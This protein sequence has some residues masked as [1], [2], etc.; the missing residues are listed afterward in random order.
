MNTYAQ[1]NESGTDIDRADN[2]Q[3]PP[4]SLG[5]P[6][7]VTYTVQLSP[8]LRSSDK[9]QTVRG[10]LIFVP[11]Q[12]QNVSMT[13][14][15][16]PDTTDPAYPGN[17]YNIPTRTLSPPIPLTIREWDATGDAPISQVGIKLSGTDDPLGWNPNND[18][19]KF[20]LAD[21]AA[22]SPQTM[23]AY[24]DPSDEAADWDVYALNLGETGIYTIEVKATV[25][26]TSDT[27]YNSHMYLPVRGIT[28]MWRCFSE[29]SGTG[30]YEE[31]CQTLAEYPWGE[32]GKLPKIVDSPTDFASDLEW[33]EYNRAHT[34]DGLATN[35]H[36]GVTRNTGRFDTIGADISPS[37][38]GYNKY[39]QTFDLY[40]NPAVTYHGPLLGAEDNCDQSAVKLYVG[41]SPESGSSSIGLCES[42]GI[43]I[44]LLGIVGAAGAAI[45][46]PG[47]QGAL[48]TAN[49]AIRQYN[50][51]LQHTLGIDGMLPPQAQQALN[52]W[53]SFAGQMG[54]AAQQAGPAIGVGAAVIAALGLAALC[55]PGGS[56]G[57]DTSSG[58]STSSDVDFSSLSSDSEISS[59]D[60]SSLSS[61]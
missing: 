49:G 48:N 59:A 26:P 45:N 9:I 12:L 50:S 21:V 60:S 56:S 37:S 39:L 42:A 58:S 61:N 40:L 32:T 11:S 2:Y 7:D 51:N 5:Q 47:S 53:N 23:S 25:T 35:G 10:A 33:L 38:R 30:G 20:S 34:L 19:A 13:L 31:G 1:V 24:P 6:V 18:V 14:T 3:I 17:D 43:G 28:G 52:D 46:L 44:L 16:A 36:C 57:M 8:L 41:E 22:D 4:A 15:H 54:G 55:L 29:S 27:M